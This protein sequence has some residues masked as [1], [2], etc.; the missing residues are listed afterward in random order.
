MFTRAKIGSVWHILL[1]LLFSLQNQFS[2]VMKM[3]NTY[4]VTGSPLVSD[5]DEAEH[6]HY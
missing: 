4:E 5:L 2:K 6:N 3:L 1:C